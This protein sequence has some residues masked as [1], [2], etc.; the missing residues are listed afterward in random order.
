MSN[1]KTLLKSQK[2]KNGYYPQPTLIGT[3]I[4]RSTQAGAQF[5]R[6]GKLNSDTPL[7]GSNRIFKDPKTD[8]EYMYGTIRSGQESQI[9]MTFETAKNTLS[10]FIDGDYQAIA[11]FM[12]SIL[13]ATG[14][15]TLDIDIPENASTFILNG[16]TKNLPYTMNGTTYTAATSLADAIE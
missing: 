6:S 3:N 10:A 2:Q 15:T 1:I 5:A 7:D 4:T 12:P 9:G 13:V 8:K 11:I 14:A 16:S